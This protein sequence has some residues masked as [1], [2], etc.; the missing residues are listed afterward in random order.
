M[1][2]FKDFKRH[3]PLL[4]REVTPPRN[5]CLFP[6][7][8]YTCRTIGIVVT[9]LTHVTLHLISALGLIR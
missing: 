8:L 5:S 4:D 7:S 9:G 1:E 6:A 2:H 3:E